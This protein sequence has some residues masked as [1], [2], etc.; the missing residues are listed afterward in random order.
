MSKRSVMATGLLRSV[1]EEVKTKHKCHTLI[2]YGSLARG[3]ATPTSDYDLLAIR[4]GGSEIVRDARVWEGVYLDVFVYP[5]KKARP[6]D[7][8]Q[9]R[10]GKVLF[11]K[12]RFGDVL[13]TRINKVHARGPKRLSSDEIA[14]RKIWA[15]KFPPFA[16]R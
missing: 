14:A 8:L 7:L 9:V 6:D 11:Q 15:R 10:G 3:D 12:N 5:E 13:L 1:V 2:L 4:R 16:D